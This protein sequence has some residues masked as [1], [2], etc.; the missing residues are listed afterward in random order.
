MAA[1]IDETP[2]VE[3][4]PFPADGHSHLTRT[5]RL[6][7][8]LGAAAAAVR[9]LRLP[10]TPAGLALAAGGL[11]LSD[12]LSRVGGDAVLPG[13]PFDEIAH[14]LTALLV[15]WALGRAVSERFMVPALIAS[16][17]IDLDHVPQLL[18]TDVLTVG[19]P[20]PYTH[21]LLTIV[22]ALVAARLWRTQGGRRVALGVALGLALH[23][24]RDLCESSTG[25]SLLWPF[26]DH[27]FALPFWSYA[28]VLVV[29]V[30]VI[31]RRISARSRYVGTTSV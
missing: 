19:T 18:G 26:S 24:W 3:P 5:A 23:F 30:A 16:V 25:V 29:V 22:V 11:V 15:I 8:V 4:A 2:G 28:G 12:R 6:A 14:G 17:T 21:S 9:R 27:V 7:A 1:A 10:P 31:A 13:G 20:R